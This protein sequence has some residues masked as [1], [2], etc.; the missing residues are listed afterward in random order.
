[1]LIKSVPVDDTSIFLLDL[2][3]SL[4]DS[5]FRDHAHLNSQDR[6]ALTQELFQQ[7]SIRLG[8]APTPVLLGLENLQSEATRWTL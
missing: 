3:A 4:Q 6:K 2:R 1:M 7:I 8:V 5:R